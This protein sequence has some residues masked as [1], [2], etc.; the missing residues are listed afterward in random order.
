MKKIKKLRKTLVPLIVG[1]MVVLV[2]ILVIRQKDPRDTEAAALHLALNEGYG[3]SVV[4]TSGTVSDGTITNAQWKTDEMCRTSKCMYFDGSGDFIEIADNANLDFAASDDFTIMGWFRH[5]EISTNTDII[6][7][8]YGDGVAGGYAVYMDSDGDIAFA[9]DDDSFWNTTDVVGDDQSKN[10][11]DNR[12]HHFAAVKDGTTGIYLYVDGI[13]IDS[14]TSLV[15]T[16]TLVNSAP[17]YVGID[18]DGASNS[19]HGYLDEIKVHREVKTAAQ[20]KADMIP[21]VPEDTPSATFGDFTRNY[22]SNGLVGYW[23][24]NEGGQNTCSGGTNDS[25]D[26]SGNSND[27]AWNGSTTMNS[28]GKFGHGVTTT[29]AN[30]V[31]VSDNNSLD[32]TTEVTI[33]TWLNRDNDDNNDVVVYKGGSA[34]ELNYGLDFSTS[35]F[36]ATP[37]F[38]LY[39]GATVTHTANSS[40]SNST[41]T[42]VA[43]TYDGEK[44]RIYINGVLN[45]EADETTAMLANT[46]TLRIGTNS[47][48]S[49]DFAGVLDE[50]RIYN[51]AL[52]PEEITNLYRWAPGPV[53]HYDFEDTQTK[54]YVD[55]G[56]LFDGTDDFIEL[57]TTTTVKNLT[58]YSV[59]LWFYTTNLDSTRRTLYEEIRG[60]TSDLTR[61]KVAIDTDNKLLFAGRGADGDSF[62]TWVDSNTVLSEDTWYH[63]VAV[64]DSVADTHYLYINNSSESASVTAATI[65]NTDP[66]QPST[67]GAA[68]TAAT[69]EEQFHEGLIRDVAIYNTALTS[70]EVSTLY[71]NGVTDTASTLIAYYPL[72]EGSGQVVNDTSDSNYD[73]TLGESSSI[74]TDDPIWRAF[75]YERDYYDVSG[76]GNTATAQ[77]I[78]DSNTTQG[79]FGNAYK[80]DGS[81]DTLSVPDSTNLSITGDLTISA[82]IKPEAVTAAT[83]F[84]I[85]GKWNDS[86]KSYLLAQYG[87]EIRMYIGSAS[88][89]ATTDAANLSA[90]TWYHI[91]GKYSASAQTI[92]VFVNGVEK[93][94]TV[95]GTIPSS[96]SDASNMLYIGTDVTLGGATGS[97]DLTIAAGTD[98]VAYND[99]AYDDTATTGPVGG[100][101]TSPNASYGQGFRF[102]NVTLTRGAEITSAYLTLMKDGA[103]STNVCWRLTAIEEDDTATFSSGSPPGA[104]AIV[105]EYIAAETV[106]SSHSNNTAYS[107]PTS[108]GLRTMLGLA[109]TQVVGRAGWASGNDLAIVNNSDQDNSACESSAR[110][111]YRMYDYGTPATNAPKLHIDYA[112]P[113]TYTN[114]FVG[115]MDEIKIYNYV[116]TDTQSIEDMNGG[117]PAGGSPI[118]SQVVYYK[119][120]ELQGT[121]LNNENS[122]Q[123]AIVGALTPAPAWRTG[124]N[125]KVNGCLDFNGTG[126]RVLVTNTTAIDLNEGLNDGFTFS[127]WVYIDSDGENDVGQIIYKGGNTYLRTSNES[128]GLV[129]IDVSL[130]LATSD[131]T[132]TITDGATI[133]SWTYIAVTY[134]NDSDDEVSVW[135]DGELRGTSTNGSGDPAA[136]SDDLS[137]GGTSTANFDGRMD[138]F[139]I[140]SSELTSSEIRVDYNIGSGINFGVGT[141]EQSNLLNGFGSGPTGWFR[142]DENTGTSTTYDVSTR[143]NNGTLNSTAWVPGVF[144]S[145]LDFD[146]SSSN[147]NIGNLSDYTIADTDDFSFSFWVNRDTFTTD[148]T[149]FSKRAG[150]SATQGGYGI[151]L[152]ASTDVV[153]VEV[154]DG[155]DEFSFTGTTAITSTGWN[156]IVVVFDQDSATNSQIY[157]NGLEDKAGT[158]GTIANVGDLTTSQSARIGLLGVASAPFDGKIDEVKFFRYALTRDQVAYEYN[159]GQGEGWWRLDEGTGTT[160]YDASAKGL[161]GTLTIGASGSNTTTATAW[162]N[163]ASGKI[164]GSI[165]LD[166]TDD[167]FQVADSNPNDLYDQYDFSVSMW[168]NRQSSTTTDVLISKRNNLSA[169]SNG[170]AVV[171]DATTDTLFAEIA[172]GTDE[173]SVTGTTAIT[174][175]GWQH[176]VFVFDQDNDTN[177]T[178]Y[179]NGVPDKASTSGTI[180]NIGDSVNVLPM[181]IGAHAGSTPADYFDGMIDDVRIFRYPLTEDQ[182]RQ[183][184]NENASVRFNE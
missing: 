91:S 69:T 121:T 78:Q 75:E 79:K 1:L 172:D 11:D 38:K 159:R 120:E 87:D 128:G 32:T 119:M 123:A 55:G 19:W 183:L 30:Y 182:V 146:G 63:V 155:T 43:A 111:V 17:L 115:T 184:Y 135:I 127:S 35:A 80:F 25:C 116:R 181:R 68:K 114:Q 84:S 45:Y 42:H 145:A 54:T 176:V 44:V 36:V 7:A 33:A 136:E 13:L 5:P 94:A 40:I 170:Y 14:D 56:V 98:D 130:D 166:G 104:R 74:E 125:C 169:S 41:W 149:I 129:D 26:Y 12:W 178:I 106:N 90:N 34:T 15:E 95:T 143:A 24:F 173:F 152:T 49:T 124:S 109:I 154:S 140:Y 59:S 2:P 8:K 53:A 142:F 102:N 151:G 164:N 93:A 89:Y 147:V 71:T 18:S 50:T 108:T 29:S 126:D 27:G 103:E 117:H 58:R 134:S 61:V 37:Q 162:S 4:D 64:Y 46:G 28:T 6:A 3:S 60:A 112:M 107:Y 113:D 57:P 138:E 105:N 22:I 122:S 81:N 177:S 21:G 165:D 85:A 150:T 167:Y 92:E 141:D 70:N 88:N 96:I 73:G 86:N 148:D 47:G 31:E 131:A 132:L 158:T 10:Y 20:I 16:G 9:I 153:Y 137:I 66:R 76:Y 39:N 175:S 174:S 99:I 133:G 72:N 168:I 83:Q 100:V 52:T 82:W 23:R 180:A 118:A 139:K 51:R 171:L 65:S 67:L 48:G 161:N 101:G 110:E 62:T 157:V 156:H 97:L 160:I 77:N 163:G 179:L 144:G